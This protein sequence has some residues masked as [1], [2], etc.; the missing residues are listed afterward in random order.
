MGIHD[1]A[2]ACVLRGDYDTAAPLFDR[3]A[4][5]SG[6]DP[7]AYR[8]YLAA[9]SDPAKIPAAV[10]ALQV[11]N[12]YSTTSASEH[13]AHLGQ[14]DEALAVLEQEYEARNPRLPWVNAHPM[15]EAFRSDPRFLDLLRRMNF[16]N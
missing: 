5:L 3:L 15:Y 9:L 4:E 1:L 14:F 2:S 8:A 6:S 11:P 10:T 7:E 16:P 13:L 12:V